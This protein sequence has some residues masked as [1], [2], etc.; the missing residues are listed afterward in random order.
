MAVAAN[1][2]GYRLLQEGKLDDAL[3]L[4]EASLNLDVRY[5]M[6]RYNLARAHALKGNA[7]ESVI[8]LRMLK[9]MGK[10]QR[11]RL[12]QASKDEAFKKVADSEEFQALFK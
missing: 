9:T 10:A 5:G 11:A 1:T 4:F 8:Y 7:K 12:Q 2:R 3:P 6:P